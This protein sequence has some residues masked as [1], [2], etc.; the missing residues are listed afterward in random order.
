M[1]KPRVAHEVS[2]ITLFFQVRPKEQIALV[3]RGDPVNKH[4]LYAFR[5]PVPYYLNQGTLNVSFP[6]AVFITI[7]EIGP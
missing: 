5:M 4:L 2:T 7:D 3:R 6:L 1:K